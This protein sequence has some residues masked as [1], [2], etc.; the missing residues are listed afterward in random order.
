M[1]V[2][3]LADLALAD[4]R[5]LIRQDLN[6]PVD[7]GVVSSDLRIKASLPAI[8]YCIE[9]GAQLMIMSHLG[10]PEEGSP[11]AQ[12][13]LQPVADILSNALGI[14]VTLVA[15]YLDN[16]PHKYLRSWRKAPATK[17]FVRR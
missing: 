15:D 1:P 12:Y 6:V 2:L 10:R 5:V 11:D 17:I 8:N 9:S 16:P 3:N 4:R 7:N 14:N 13:S